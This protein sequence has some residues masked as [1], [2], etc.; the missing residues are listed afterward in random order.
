MGRNGKFSGLFFCGAFLA[1]FLAIFGCKNPAEDVP[2][3][4]KDTT[5][6]FLQKLLGSDRGIVENSNGTFT[7]YNFDGTIPVPEGFT[8]IGLPDD[9]K[10]LLSDD[11]TRLELHKLGTASVTVF[12]FSS[13]GPANFEVSKLNEKYLVILP[14]D[15]SYIIEPEGDH[16]IVKPYT[17]ENITLKPGEPDA[18]AG[19]LLILQAYVPSNNPAGIS[20]PFVELYNTTDAEI[21]LDGITLYFADGT[22]STWKMISL[23]GKTIPAEASFLIMGPIAG[24][25]PVVTINPRLTLEDGYGD[26]ND[27]AFTMSNN[28]YKIALI[29]NTDEL[30]VENPFTMDGAGIA[31]G[32]I[33]MVGTYN[34]GALETQTEVTGYETAPARGSASEAARRG[35]LDDTDDNSADFIRLRYANTTSAGSVSVHDWNLD[36]YKPKN[37]SYNDGEGWDPFDEPEEPNPPP[38]PTGN[39]LLILQAYGGSNANAPNHHFVELYNAGATTV[40]LS[41][42]SLQYAARGTSSAPEGDWNVIPLTGSI[43]PNTSY[44]VLGQKIVTATSSRIKIADDAGDVNDSSFTLNNNGFKVALI[45]GTAKLTVPNPYNTDGNWTPASGYIDMV[46]AINTPGTD[47]ITGYEGPVN[48][49]LPRNSSQE[50]IRRVSLIDTDINVNDFRSVRYTQNS[51]AN[52]NG[53]DDDELYH[54]TP[55]NTA[56]GAWAPFGDTKAITEDPYPEP[57]GPGGPFVEAGDEDALAKQ[58]LI[59]Q[60]YVP[61]NNPAGISHPFVELY[62]TTDAEIDMDGITLYFAN[63][64]LSTWK[65]ISLNGKTI[66]AKTSFLVMGPKAGTTT[67]TRLVLPDDYGDIN[68]PEF[69]M[70][71]NGY[72]ITLIRNTDELNVE[73]PFTMD[74][75]GIAD[76]YIDMVGTYNNGAVDNQ[77]EVTGYET[78]PARGSASMAARRTGLVDND[79]NSLDF[80]STDYR[81][82]AMNEDQ[83]EIKRPKNSAYGAWNPITGEREGPPVDPGEPDELAKKLLIF[84]AYGTGQTGVAVSHSFVELYNATEEEINLDGYSMYYADGTSTNSNGSSGGVIGLDAAWNRVDLS[85][86]RMPGKASLLVLGAPTPSSNA[87]TGLTL[88]GAEADI[89]VPTM[90][91][92]NRTFKI[93]VIKSSGELADVNPF[94]T[95]GNGTKTEGYVDLLGAQNTAGIDQIQAYE[96]TPTRNSASAG[97]RRKNL[98]DTDN[99]F[100]DFEEI[101]YAEV[102]AEVLEV[103]RPRNLAYGGWDPFEE[104][105]ANPETERLMILQANTYGN[106]TGGFDKSLVELY[107]NTDAAIDLTAGN[108]YLHIGNATA[109]T[110]QIKLTGTILS[111]HSFLIVTNNSSDFNGNARAAH[112]PAFP[113]ADQEANFKIINSDFKVAVLKNQATLSV[114]NPFV[115]PGLADDYV[116]MLGVGA[117]N[118]YETIPASTSRPQ[119]PRRTSLVDTDNNK[120]DFAQWDSRSTGVS[121]TELLIRWPKNSAYG[122]WNPI[123]GEQLGSQEPSPGFT[124][125]WIKEGEVNYTAVVSNGDKISDD[126]ITISRGAT[127]EITP[128]GYSSYRWEYNRQ[129]VGTDNTPYIF[130]GTASGTYRILLKVNGTQQGATIDIVVQ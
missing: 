30:N 59:L 42:Y 27:P 67:S 15:S 83:L 54:Y 112:L 56:Y 36:F 4:Q 103:R 92:N 68:D 80:A 18:L 62:N 39:T 41:G 74:G 129:P 3:T 122:P 120:T 77:T 89:S 119:P 71:N 46:G 12:T 7:V 79:D 70:T 23:D 48:S 78:L 128:V 81:A 29:R 38:G 33:D 31:D 123:T 43:P 5:K 118:G 99:N 10:A 22:A 58:L 11:D 126:P 8:P 52:A 91:L 82:T 61:S 84:Q 125:E 121:A 2:Q 49:A 97:P 101:R 115:D 85:G 98:I 53:I 19:E 9:L 76:G 73:N 55:K 47:I 28:G 20:H 124:L 117:A 50:G 88:T 90:L 69:T 113:S 63:G 34:N 75:A 104:P 96:G 16:H 100:N 109:W 93:A 65:M 32:Y 105:A 87:I 107:N 45:N 25:N 57:T 64:T 21:D 95:D 13:R 111:K 130:I 44:L 35:S 14:D 86:K 114:N 6:S 108:Y 60:A 17:P 66:P 94:N 24:T 116:D 106:D 1:I 37:S 110:F 102:S 40:S 127:I 51:T 26:I 72:K